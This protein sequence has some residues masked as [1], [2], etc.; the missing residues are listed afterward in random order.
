MIRTTSRPQ[1]SMR[2]ILGMMMML[3][4]VTFTTTLTLTTLTTLTLMT[5][6]TT[7]T[8]PTGWMNPWL[9]SGRTGKIDALIDASLIAD[10]E[11]DA[12]INGDD[13]DA[14]DDDEVDDDHDHD[15]AN[16]DGKL[17]AVVAAVD[18]LDFRSLK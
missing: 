11:K 8:T 7:L 4:S 3:T 17:K 5:L 13:D 1:L 14:D 2:G 6:I 18:E 16:E 9:I 12:Q 10:F 15:H